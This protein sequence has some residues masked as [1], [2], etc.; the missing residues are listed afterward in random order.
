MSFCISALHLVSFRL[1]IG[2]GKIA[3]RS[4]SCASSRERVKG[5]AWAGEEEDPGD[6]LEE[7]LGGGGGVAE[8]SSLWSKL[9]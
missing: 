5:M 6:V 2:G 8:E 3:L 4:A 1:E 9:K 7:K